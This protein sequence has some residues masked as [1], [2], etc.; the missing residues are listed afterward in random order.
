MLAVAS[1]AAGSMCS[2]LQGG[3][4]E[5]S[6]TERKWLRDRSCI[7][8]R[9]VANLLRCTLREISDQIEKKLRRD[10]QRFHQSAIFEQTRN[11]PAGDIAGDMALSPVRTG[12]T[13]IMRQRTE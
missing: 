8:R 1:N 11:G 3:S 10:L 9:G 5:M 12:D 2:G 13:Q 4:G 6:E 7:A